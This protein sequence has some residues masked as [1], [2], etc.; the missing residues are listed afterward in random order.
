VPTKT[1][2]E[3][4]TAPDPCP[5]LPIEKGPEGK[6]VGSWVCAD[7]HR[8][9]A[10]YLWATRGAWAGWDKRI[11]IDPFC[12]TGRIQGV[13]EQFTR[14][15][16]AVRAWLSLAADAPF[17]GMFVGDKE[18][19]RAAAC[20]ARLEAI[21]A[22]ARAFPGLANDTVP[23]MVKATPH[24]ALCMA[25]VDP[26]NLELLSFSI[27]KQLAA[28]PKVD[29]AINFSTMDLWRNVVTEFGQSRSRF[30]AVAPGWRDDPDVRASGAKNMPL[31]FFNYWFKLVTELDFEHSKAM[32]I[33]RNNEGHPI[34]RM[35]FFTRHPLPKRIWSDVARGPNLEMF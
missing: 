35:V 31:A 18:P 17:T 22:P 30:D 10:N 27:L 21:G 1:P 32:P 12:A 23:Q 24:G 19:E 15:G 5:D 14:P 25:Y 33:V 29:L 26:Y 2:P 6:G 11:Y 8:L 34:Y 20:E 16:G 3:H 13:G 4:A 28:L 7:K 9:L